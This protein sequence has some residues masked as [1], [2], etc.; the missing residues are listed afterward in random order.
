[1]ESRAIG[2]R[3]GDSYIGTSFGTSSWEPSPQNYGSNES[4]F[5]PA[6]MPPYTSREEVDMQNHSALELWHEHLVLSDRA[7]SSAPMPTR[8]ADE[9]GAWD[10]N[11]PYATED[12]HRC[13]R[14]KARPKVA[15][16][17]SHRPAPTPAPPSG[18][19]EPP[20]PPA[21]LWWSQNGFGEEV[22]KQP[23]V[24]AARSRRPAPPSGVSGS[25]QPPALLWCSQ[26]L[27]GEEEMKQFAP[28][29]RHQRYFYF[30]N[31]VK[32]TRWFCQQHR[33]SIR[34][35][36]VLVT[37]WREAKPCL[38]ACE[39]AY[40]GDEGKLRPDG[41]R[42]RLKDPALSRPCSPVEI[43]VSDVFIQSGMVP[44]PQQA[45]ICAWVE[46]IR[47]SFPSLEI[48]VVF[49]ASQLREALTTVCGGAPDRGASPGVGEGESWTEGE[50]HFCSDLGDSGV[51]GAFPSVIRLSF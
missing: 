36:S 1:M 11:M 18:A 38:A 47:S 50:S 27:Y 45:K 20:Q 51:N 15:A 21:L 17:R 48:H 8:W 2:D 43:A 40:T 42:S 7:S 5:C 19:S 41:R 4:S 3:C 30:Q 46:S 33:G 35:W 29:F 6:S 37:G 16:A 12:S 32:F 22:L 28:Y 13:A 14:P 24:P 34:P 49:G 31:S 26:N 9:C 23:K 25:P 44:A 39:A 10:S